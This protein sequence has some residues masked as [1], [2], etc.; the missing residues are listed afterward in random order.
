MS[1][2][3]LLLSEMSATMRTVLF[4]PGVAPKALLS[5]PCLKGR[6]HA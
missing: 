2:L 6:A 5:G 3:G 4:L 1:E